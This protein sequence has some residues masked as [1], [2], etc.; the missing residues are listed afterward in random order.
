MLSVRPD[1][2]DAISSRT[3]ETEESYDDYLR[4]ELDLGLDM[5][6]TTES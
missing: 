6:D 4:R 3:N 1:L 5:E 2:R